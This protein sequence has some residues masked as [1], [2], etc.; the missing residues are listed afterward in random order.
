MH[1]LQISTARRILSYGQRADVRPFV[2]GQGNNRSICAHSYAT[3][4]I[5]M[6]VMCFP[7]RCRVSVP[8]A[9][10]MVT[11]FSSTLSSDASDHPCLSHCSFGEDIL[12]AK[13]ARLVDDAQNRRVPLSLDG[14]LYSHPAE[15]PLIAHPVGIAACVR[16]LGIADPCQHSGARCGDKHDFFSLR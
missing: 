12:S 5:Q 1:L 11:L 15:N 3:V 9:P 8:E 6:G 2:P 10:P 4:V 16:A 14:V 13:T 7:Q